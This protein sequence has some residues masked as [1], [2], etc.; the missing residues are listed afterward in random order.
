MYY[1]YC[2][3]QKPFAHFGPSRQFL[4]LLEGSPTSHAVSVVVLDGLRREALGVRVLDSWDNHRFQ[5]HSV[6]H[7]S[8]VSVRNS[9]FHLCYD[10]GA[11]LLESAL[12]PISPAAT[13]MIPR[14]RKTAASHTQSTLAARIIKVDSYHIVHCELGVNAAHRGFDAGS[15]GGHLDWITAMFRRLRDNHCAGD[16][17]Q[18]RV[19]SIIKRMISVV[20]PM[21]ELQ[22]RNASGSSIERT[23]SSVTVGLGISIMMRLSRHGRP[24][25]FG[26]SICYLSAA[27][28][29]H[30]V[31][32]R[33]EI[34]ANVSLDLWHA[35]L[36]ASKLPVL[37]RDSNECLPRAM[38]NRTLCDGPWQLGEPHPLPSKF[39]WE[40]I[41]T[42]P[43]KRSL[44]HYRGRLL[45]TASRSLL[46]FV[47]APRSAIFHHAQTLSTR[48]Y[49][50]PTEP[51]DVRG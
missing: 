24:L 47:L 8:A 51:I 22:A 1:R 34:F 36:L 12:T 6:L 40:A 42:Y 50:T 7:S 29:G 20:L 27:R 26:T 28:R 41:L 21:K 30:P 5:A 9:Q 32:R 44:P 43:P 33:A 17:L 11:H 45:A 14:V 49:L 37:W 39:E 15:R 23:Q 13:A 2:I 46:S 18:L 19:A 10:C 31:G 48:R 25:L 38:Q 3:S 4:D 16:A 35:V